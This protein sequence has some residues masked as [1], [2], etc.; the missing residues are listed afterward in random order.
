MGPTVI[1]SCMEG[2][3]ECPTEARTEEPGNKTFA[4]GLHWACIGHARTYAHAHT[5]AHE[6]TSLYYYYYKM[7]AV[8]CA[9]V[10]VV[11]CVVSIGETPVFI[12]IS[13]CRA[14]CR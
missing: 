3:P 5:L 4:L 11:G 2:D 9:V 6:K 10:C 8:V 12:G 1:V 13:L 14:V 7:C